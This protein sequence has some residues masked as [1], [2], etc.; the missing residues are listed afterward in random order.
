MKKISIRTICQVALLVALEIVLN[1]FCSIN[2][3]A[4]KIGFSFVPIA[5]CAALFGPAWAA[6]AYAAADFLGAILF[7]IGPY[8]PGFTVC[9]AVKGI[10]FGIFIYKSLSNSGIDVIVPKWK[11]IKIFPNIVVAAIINSI[12][13]GLLV[14]TLWVSMLYG[15]KTYWGWF[16]Y[17]LPQFAVLVPVQIILIP[18]ILKLADTL[19]KNGFIEKKKKEV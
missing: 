7:P 8:H 18:A 17:R 6:I 14:D 9:A 15:S 5:L 2:T 1:R 12:V 19:K 10:V 13:I 4:L 3:S 16:V 11:K